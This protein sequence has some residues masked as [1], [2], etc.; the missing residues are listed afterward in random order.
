MGIDDL[1]RELAFFHDGVIRLNP[2]ASARDLDA[3][4][5][6][7]DVRLSPSMRA[8]LA[9]FNG[10]LI[11]SEPVMGVPPIQSALDLVFATRQARSYWGPLGWSPAYV[12]VGN[13]GAGSPFVLLLDRTDPSGESPVGVFDTGR[14]TVDE[15]VASSYVSFVWF[16]TQDV[17]WGHDA[18]GVPRPGDAVR[19]TPKR[20]TVRPAALSPWR[21]NEAWMLAHDPAL[22]RWR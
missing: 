9:A 12:E 6:E 17:R 8:V 11:V 10:G 16:L 5:H 15:I 3:A 20:V 22:A 18:D 1:R 2:P 19:W 7:L 4:E 21:V 13:D 14:M